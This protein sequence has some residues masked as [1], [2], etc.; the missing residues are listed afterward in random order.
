M[1]KHTRLDARLK[2]CA[3]TSA[4]AMR[5]QA[6]THQREITVFALERTIHL[7]ALRKAVSVIDALQRGESTPAD[8][9]VRS[10]HWLDRS[11]LQMI[12][13]SLGMSVF[14]FT[15]VDLRPWTWIVPC[16]CGA[17]AILSTLDMIRQRMASKK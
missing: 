16:V 8:K 14:Y 5:E 17:V 9:K 7:Q 4:L 12:A 1:S 3:R 11:R 2:K 6:L 10:V 15:L 13:L